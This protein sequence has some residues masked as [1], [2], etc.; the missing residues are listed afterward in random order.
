M[1]EHSDLLLTAYHAHL[2]VLEE[3]VSRVA[4]VDVEVDLHSYLLQQ[5]EVILQNQLHLNLIQLQSFLLILT[6]LSPYS[7]V[8]Y[9]LEKLWIFLQV[10]LKLVDSFAVDLV[11]LIPTL[12]HGCC[13]F[14]HHLCFVLTTCLLGCFHHLVF[15]L[16]LAL[17]FDLACLFRLLFLLFTK[18]LFCSLFFAFL[19]VVIDFLVALV[20]WS[21][22]GRRLILLF[23]ALLVL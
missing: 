8:V 16:S 7:E 3:E 1:L 11:V 2:N 19:H 14:C 4:A 15:N 21:A 5:D 13:S 20:V 9:L 18:H 10:D 23:L 17:L 12:T 6:P 22:L